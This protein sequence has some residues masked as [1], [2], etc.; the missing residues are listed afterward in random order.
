MDITVSRKINLYRWLFTLGIVIYHSKSLAAFTSPET[1]I[2]II[3]KTY[4]ILANQ[5]GFTSMNFFFFTSGFLLYFNASPPSI[6]RKMKSRVKSLLLPFLLWQVTVLI[7]M[8]LTRPSEARLHLNPIDSFFCSP[9][10]GPLWYCLALLILMLPA[11]LI[12][13]I[14]HKSVLTVLTIAIFTYLIARHL[15]YFPE[16]LSFKRWWWYGNMISYLPSY[17][18]G[19]YIGIVRPNLIVKPKTN[20]NFWV[21]FGIFLTVIVTVLWHYSP[22]MLSDVNFGLLQLIGMWLLLKSTWL[23]KDMPKFFDCAFYVFALH[24]PILIPEFELLILPLFSI[25]VPFNDLEILTL[26]LLEIVS[27]VLASWALKLLFDRIFPA[28]FSKM[29]T[30]GR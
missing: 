1:K 5:L 27:I 26:K 2:G 15:G 22:G 10:A 3:A 19:A 9:V 20:N 13:R 25:F 12:V 23:T 16:P 14:K 30:G 4:V 8:T 11:P 7:L 28:K 24:N 6:R 21:L 17:I 29:F 18:L